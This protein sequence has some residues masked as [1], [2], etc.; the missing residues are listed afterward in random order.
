MDLRGRSRRRIAFRIVLVG[1]VTLG[2]AGFLLRHVDAGVVVNMIARVEAG[3]VLGGLAV[4]LFGHLL[5]YWR[6]SLV[7][8][9]PHGP[10]FL[11]STALHGFAS[12]VLPLR[13]GELVLPIMMRRQGI[14]GLPRSLGGLLL[15][16]I[17]DAF[18]V[19]MAGAVVFLARP[20][21]A[22]VATFEFEDGLSTGLMSTFVFVFCTAGLWLVGRRLPASGGCKDRAQFS[23]LSVTIWLSVTGMNMAVLRALGLDVQPVLLLLLLVLGVAVM[24]TPIQGFAGLGGHQ[25]VWVLALAA[26]GRSAEAALEVAL[27]SHILIIFYV[28]VLGVVGLGLMLWADRRFRA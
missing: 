2:A 20:D 27:A 11:A 5:R 10:E 7:W 12:Y 16:R 13:L 4:F 14:S 1:G 28:C 8:R 26:S 24:V 6:Y 18:L 15:V 22:P 9:W 23:L 17:Y 19:M 25:L 21:L 3:W